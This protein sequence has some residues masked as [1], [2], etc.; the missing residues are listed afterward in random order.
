V[1][2]LRRDDFDEYTANEYRKELE[3]NGL[4]AKVPNNVVLLGSII[5]KEKY[6]KPIF[7]PMC[8]G[9][10]RN[11]TKTWSERIRSVQL[12]CGGDDAR[13]WNRVIQ[14][15]WGRKPF[16]PWDIDGCA[17][18]S[19]VLNECKTIKGSPKRWWEI[20]WREFFDLIGMVV[21]DIDIR[22]LNLKKR[23]YGYPES[24]LPEEIVNYCHRW[25][26]KP[27]NFPWGKRIRRD[28]Q[29]KI[30]EYDPEE[31]TIWIPRELVTG[32]SC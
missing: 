18:E 30:I 31:E 13:I 28:S 19:V 5:G 32:R 7:T 29:N 6:V 11:I 14:L 2:R 20:D 1:W 10:D 22:S 9:G 3:G 27:M 26:M 16:L 12:E 8:L 17:A 4:M 24:W 25:N 23:L 21:N 15:K